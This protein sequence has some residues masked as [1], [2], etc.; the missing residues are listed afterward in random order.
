[1]VTWWSPAAPNMPETGQN[2]PAIGTHQNLIQ[3]HFSALSSTGMNCRL[4]S[5]GL[6]AHG[7]NPC[8]PTNKKARNDGL[9]SF[10]EPLF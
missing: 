10:L 8:T 3:S 1:M 4:N 2:C 9:S 6:G 7:S 5:G